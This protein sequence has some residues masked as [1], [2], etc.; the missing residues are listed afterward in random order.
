MRKAA[1]VLLFLAAFAAFAAEYPEPVSG[2]FQ[3]RD[4]AFASGEKLPELTIHYRT[5]GS[6]HRNA[7][8]AIDNAVLIL[9]GTTGSG[10]G[11]LSPN[12]AGF[13]FGPGQI[14]DASRYY[15]ILPDG[16][17]H[18]DS[19]RPSDSRGSG[20]AL[21]ARFPH[22]GYDDMVEAQRALLVDGLGVKHV[23]LILGTSM[24]AMHCWVWGEK[25]PGFMDG[26]VPLAS[27]PTEIA[28][29]NRIL[30]KMIIDTIRTDP[31]WKDGE[32]KTQPRS[33]EGA[34]RL[35]LM[36][37]SAPQ[38]WQAAAPTRD[39]ADAYYVDLMKTRLAGADANNFLYAFEASR[40]YDPSRDLERI[41]APVLAIN[42]SDDFV[43]PPELG[44]MEKL[45]PRVKRGRYV[46]VPGT[47]ETKGH[48]T[49]TWPKFW[50]E[51]L[52]AFLEMLPASSR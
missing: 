9:H 44:L 38:A 27:V 5:V 40:D 45:M 46:L 6:P 13:L 1:F 33:L 42:S 36:M 43:N 29:R 12:F 47:A 48:S 24:G 2:D 10:K 18:G 8:G 21:H 34:V 16:I 30:R 37:V 11:F 25:H 32:Y 35:L 20:P 7:S 26:L 28:G 14:L 17:G 39:A 41:E 19:S 50:G 4:F 23:R 31:E 49:H 3:I 22:Y 51:N 15:L 52:K